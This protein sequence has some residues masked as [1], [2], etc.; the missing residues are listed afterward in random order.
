MRRVIS[1][2]LVCVLPLVARELTLEQAVEQAITGNRGFASAAFEVE[3]AQ[4]R[5][6]QAGLPRNPELEIGA[7]TDVLFKNEG[8]RGITV[9]L[10]Q[11]IAR[12]NRLAKARE[13]ANLSVEQQ[14][15]LI[16]DAERQLIGEVQSLFLRGL[17]LD[18]QHAARQ[19]LVDH[20]VKFA[21]IIEQRYK[22]GEVPQTD[23]API[24]IEIAKVRQ[25]Q[26]LLLAEKA[27]AELKLKFVI[28]VPPDEALTV[29]G[30]L[31]EIM[32]RWEAP[33]LVTGIE[34]RPD[35]AA[36][37]IATAQ[38]EAEIQVA[39]A[40]AYEDVTVGVDYEGERAVF[41]PPIGVKKDYYLGFKVSIPLPV[42]NKNQGRIL[43]QQAARRQAEAELASVRQKAISEVAQARSAAE[44]LGPIL[45]RYREELIP[46]AE[47]HYQAVQRAY[48]Q[49]QEG[50]APVFQAQQQHFALEVDYLTY[51]AR[52]IDALVTIETASGAHPHV[53]QHPAASSHPH[54]SIQP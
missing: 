28:G 11:A 46:L 27:D 29:V 50:I 20:G 16:R 44:K 49:G 9:G 45:A 7:R 37:K 5:A 22:A 52:R 51:L 30:D 21:A 40:D 32:K 38:A 42:R 1:I 14:R 8:E 4:G 48:Q 15:A 2:F 35:Y 34:Q 10:S 3:K 33:V 53:R 54:S 17:S 18:R 36:A 13:A 39:K 25:E 12:K 19:R 41:D 31:D 47:Q 24:Q 43:E 23:I 26:Q 6:L